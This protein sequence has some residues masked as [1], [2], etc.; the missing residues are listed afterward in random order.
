MLRQKLDG[1]PKDR[2]I[3]MFCTG[4]IRCVKTNAFVEQELGFTRTYR[5]RDGIHGYLRHAMETPGLQ[6]KWTGENF[7]FY[8]HG[9]ESESEEHDEE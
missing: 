8:E 5:L 7:V 4:G 9:N 6:S 1:V 3:M 2:P